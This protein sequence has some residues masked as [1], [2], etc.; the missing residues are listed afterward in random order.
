MAHEGAHNTGLRSPPTPVRH[1]LLIV[2]ATALAFVLA[3]ATQLIE[4][5]TTGDESDVVLTAATVL[6]VL[7][8]ATVVPITEELVFRGVLF[9]GLRDRRL[10]AAPR[11]PGPPTRMT[12]LWPAIVG[13]SV[14]FGVSHYEVATVAGMATLVLF[15]AVMAVAYEF[16]GRLWVPIAVHSTYNLIRGLAELDVP[17][18]FGAL[19]VLTLVIAAAGL[20]LT[21]GPPAPRGFVGS[22]HDA[23]PFGRTGQY[24]PIEDER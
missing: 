14:L 3:A 12:Q 4:T 20:A 22:G 19:L 5:A 18:Y 23:H 10:G 6:T 11:W 7:G 17:T 15:G 16:T 24:S 9:Q 8:G 1:W 21:T 2:A 13:S